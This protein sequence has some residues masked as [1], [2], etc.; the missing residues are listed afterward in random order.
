MKGGIEMEIRAKV[1]EQFNDKENNGI[2]RKVN[3]EIVLTEGRFEK[4]FANGFVKEIEGKEFTIE[5]KEDEE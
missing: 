5:H 3:D 2:R 4:L 1:I